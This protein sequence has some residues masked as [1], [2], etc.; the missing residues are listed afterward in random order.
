ML[1][2][3]ISLLC[4]LMVLLAVYW[5]VREIRQR[6]RGR[7]CFGCRCCHSCDGAFSDEADKADKADPYET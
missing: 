4:I 2:E 1:G 6:I 7:G 5:I 3:G